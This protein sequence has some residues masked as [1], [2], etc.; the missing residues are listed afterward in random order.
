[1]K[2]FVLILAGL[3]LFAIGL[4]IGREQGK[5]LAKKVGAAEFERGRRF[6]CSQPGTS[7]DRLFSK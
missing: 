6:D 5:D 1:M 7:F 3:F 2:R 4:D